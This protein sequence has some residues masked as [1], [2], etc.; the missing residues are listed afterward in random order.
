MGSHHFRYVSATELAMQFRLRGKAAPDLH[1]IVF[2]NLDKH[3]C[4]D[5]QLER[6]I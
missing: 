2:A 3:G 4:R 5:H 6:T 1:V